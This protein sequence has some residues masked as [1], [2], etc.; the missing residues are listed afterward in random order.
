MDT[1][2]L[3][4]SSKNEIEKGVKRGGAPLHKILSPSPLKERGIRG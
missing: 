4:Q 3:G 2:L 1:V